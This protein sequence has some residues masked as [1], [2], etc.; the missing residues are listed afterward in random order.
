MRN[1]VLLKSFPIILVVMLCMAS[2]VLNVQAENW[3]WN[4]VANNTN[5]QSV[6]MVNST[7]GWAVGFAGTIIH[8]DGTRWNNI[9][10]PTTV[11]LRA[12][13][14]IN[15]EEGWAIAGNIGGWGNNNS[16]IKLDGTTWQNLSEPVSV[17]AL[18]MMS[19]TD[20]WAVGPAGITLHWDGTNW[21]RVE[22]PIN[23]PLESVDFI[24]SNDGWAVGRRVQYSGINYMLHWN[25][26]GWNAVESPKMVG[27]RTLW[28]VDMVS[29]SDAWAV[30][31]S[32]LIIRWDGTTWQNVTSPT[33]KHLFSVNMVN[34][35]DGWAVGSDGCILRWDGA[36][37]SNVASPTGAWL[38]CVNMVS[39][40]DGWIVGADGIYRWQEVTGFPTIYLIIIS[41]IIAIIVVAWFLIRK[42]LIQ[43][44]HRMSSSRLLKGNKNRSFEG[45]ISK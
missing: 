32:G 12:V 4:K 16:I 43:C 22:T 36:S 3:S 37:W 31:D 26:T 29:S 24:N 13:D 10:S 5:L 40:T 17:E 30:G 34:E 7:D 45:D 38:N 35:T 44:R 8:W 28:A 1:D 2:L 6:D 33:T 15:P 19:S 41:A 39:S 27:T 23:G 21:T 14:M 20:G 25:G 11:N 18:D 9:G 42:R